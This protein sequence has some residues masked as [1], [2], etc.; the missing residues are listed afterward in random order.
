M[1]DKE[2]SVV[3]PVY[4]MADHVSHLAGEIA[5]LAD[6]EAQVIVVDDGSRDGSVAALRELAAGTEAVTLVECGENAG[7]GVA[8]NIGFPQA[9]GR[10]TLFFDGDDT[11]H[12]EDIRDTMAVLDRT[13]ADASLNRYEFIREGGR[14]ST[15]MNVI[16]RRLWKKYFSQIGGAAFLLANAPDLLE[17]TNYP[18]NKLVRTA[19]YQ[20][21]GL[22]PLFG[23]T[24]V[25]NDILGHWNILLY[26]RRLVLVDRTIVT[27]RVSDARDHLSNRFGAERLE[28]FAALRSVHEILRADPE[29]SAFYA[30][31]YWSLAHRLVTWAQD[32][33]ND[34]AVSAAF[35]REA[36]AL[37]ADISFE[38]L[39]GANCADAAG[40][41]RW[42]LERL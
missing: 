12:V 28:L 23:R 22:E 1:S 15:G 19:H 20:S 40:S 35:V 13:G 7:A 8:R 4:N 31:V 10:Y 24:R 25:N 36:E 41:Y 2:L 29:R 18:W 38:E 14:T 37:V 3:I 27:H 21:L 33:V 39:L 17:F 26:A 16:D 30:P 6:L 9:V 42:I 34:S 11:L 5:K 32:H